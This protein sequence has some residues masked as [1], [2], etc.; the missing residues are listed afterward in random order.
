MN[1]NK[2]PSV[3]ESIVAEELRDLQSAIDDFQLAR[4][5]AARVRANPAALQEMHEMLQRRIRE[6][7]A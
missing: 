3:Y 1:E 5:I 4:R 2:T 6:E 7:R